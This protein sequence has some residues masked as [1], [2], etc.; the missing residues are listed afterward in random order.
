MQN[1]FQYLFW[2]A[3]AFFNAVMDATENAPNFDESIFKNL[4]K[5][6]WLK[7]QSWKYAMKI[8]GWKADC[9]HISKSLMIICIAAAATFY[10]PIL[11]P[12]V[13]F[14]VLGISWNLTFTFFYHVI[15]KVK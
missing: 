4:P 5:Q 14:I 3:A 11:R 6:F 10:Q 8:L 9:W 12:W 1:Y 2:I 7:E 15:F 13:H